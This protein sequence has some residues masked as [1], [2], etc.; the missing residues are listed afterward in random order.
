MRS[1]MRTDVIRPNHDCEHALPKGKVQKTHR[2]KPR[3]DPQEPEATGIGLYS[4]LLNPLVHTLLQKQKI[5]E[6][7]D[8]PLRLKSL[9]DA[10][11][12]RNILT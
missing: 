11:T 7:A 8:T 1:K 4:Y 6:R 10:G 12:Q 5:R 3:A 2:E 9:Q